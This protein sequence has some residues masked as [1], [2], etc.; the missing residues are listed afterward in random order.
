MGRAEHDVGAANVHRAHLA[1]LAGVHRIDRGRVQDRVTSLERAVDRGGLG[2]VAQRRLDILDAERPER[3]VD[4]VGRSREHPDPVPRPGE[5]RHRVGA[6]VARS[7]GDQH[8][9]PRHLRSRACSRAE[10]I[11]GRANLRLGSSREPA[12]YYGS[13]PQLPTA[14]N[15]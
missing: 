8:Q 5:R 9:Q 14:L 2:H 13:S 6:D 12:A 7:S 15:E 10:A 4:P 3:R 1:G 11:F